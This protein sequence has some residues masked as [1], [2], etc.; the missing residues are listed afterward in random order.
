MVLGQQKERTKRQAL[1]WNIRCSIPTLAAS[2]S[3]YIT[4]DHGTWNAA[5]TWW[6]RGGHDI[7]SNGHDRFPKLKGTIVIRKNPQKRDGKWIK[8]RF[9]KLFRPLPPQRLRLASSF[10]ACA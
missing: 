8:S 4:Q 1:K 5:H 10:S 6:L 7:Y 3:A 2:F 9:R